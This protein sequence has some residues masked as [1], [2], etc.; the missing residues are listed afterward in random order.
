MPANNIHTEH[1]FERH[2]SAHLGEGWRV[3]DDD[4]GFDPHAALFMPDFVEFLAATAPHKLEKLKRE[5]GA[6]WQQVLEKTLVRE[7]ERRGTVQVLRKGFP[8]AGYQTVTC[9]APYPDDPRISHASADYDANVLR[10]MHQVHYQTAGSKSLDAV[11]FINGIPVAT[12]EVKT[13]LTQTAQDAIDEYRD[14][15]K[16]VEPD[17]GRKNPLLMYKRGAVVHFAVSEDEVWMTT[18]LGDGSRRDF[19]PRFLPFNMGNAGHAGNPPAPEGDYKTHYLWDYILER[20][21]WLSIFE[22]FVF[23]KRESK[24]DATGRMRESR[25]QIFPR[26]HQFDSVRKIVEDTRGKGPGQRYLVE[27]SPGSGKTETMSWLAHAR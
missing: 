3:S 17:T 6:G 20:D 26:F 25:T 22:S 23:E 4:K 27:H 24:P 12:M 5:K 14:E 8:M 16:P 9:M 7:L 18:D 19:S 15:R 2:I 13:E 10:F 21:N 11:M 1:W